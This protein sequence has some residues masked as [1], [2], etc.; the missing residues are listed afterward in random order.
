MI[1]MK[2]IFTRAVSLLLALLL[3][4]APALAIPESGTDR[5]ALLKEIRELLEAGA[6]YIPEDLSLDGFTAAGLERDEELFGKIVAS[7]QAED[8]YGT[9]LTRGE[10]MAR[11]GA[12]GAVLHGIGIRVDMSMPLGVYVQGFLPGGGAERSGIEVGAQIVS[13][14]GVCVADS[15]YT[16]VRHLFLGERRSVA[17]IGYINPGSAEV[18]FEEIRR[19]ILNTARVRGHIIDGTDVG[20]IHIER[21]GIY[22]DAFRYDE[23]YNGLFPEMGAKSVIIDLRGNPGG[24]LDAAAAMLNMMLPDEGVLLCTQ[25]GA[26]GEHHV[27][28]TGR[29]G[30]IWEPEGIVVLVDRNTASASEFFAGALQA[31]GLAVVAGETTYG[32][33]HSQYHLDLST[34][35]VLIFTTHRVDLYDIG[36]YDGI[37]IT[38]DYAVGLRKVTGAE[39][40]MLPLDTSR[41]LF[42]QSSMTGRV[43]AMQERLALLGYY[44]AEPGGVFDDYTLWCLNRFQVAH[45]LDQ[46]RFANAETLRMLDKAALEVVKWEDARLEFALDLLINP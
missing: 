32:K 25:V 21:F 43:T 14:D 39:A 2:K 5:L 12:G 46:G 35:D 26:D 20:Y 41:A 28:S 16:D 40:D 1:N 19:G 8:K 29:V 17:E 18:I 24:Q 34:G 15:P 38:P 27:Y 30:K 3:F 45:G 13:V 33:S 37:G 22:S 4:A 31:H 10:Y 11:F 23:Y 9:F 7:W 44:R 36:S 42:R 6:L